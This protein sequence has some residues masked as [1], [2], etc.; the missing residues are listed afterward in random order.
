MSILFL[1]ESSR[2]FNRLHQA[3]IKTSTRSSQPLFGVLACRVVNMTI[4]AHIDQ[5]PIPNEY[6][7][8]FKERQHHLQGLPSL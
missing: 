3:L 1:N 2:T 8:Y 4:Q 5:V 6:A 7:Q